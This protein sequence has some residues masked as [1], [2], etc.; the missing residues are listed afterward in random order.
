MGV[1]GRC[2][3]AACASL[4][5]ERERWQCDEMLGL[6]P[7]RVYFVSRARDSL[8]DAALPIR[9]WRHFEVVVAQSVRDAVTLLKQRG[10]PTT[11]I[12]RYFFSYEQ[13]KGRFRFI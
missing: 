6:Y 11:N 5:R 3:K 13:S 7:C 2:I 10:C 8:Q 1:I 12:T 9:V 4:D